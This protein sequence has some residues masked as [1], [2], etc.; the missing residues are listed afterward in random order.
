M[1]AQDD[2]TQG[3]D[4]I[5]RSAF[6]SGSTK[7]SYKQ[8]YRPEYDKVAA[9]LQGGAFP[10]PFPTTLMGSGL[11]KVERGRRNFPSEPPPPPPP[12]TGFDIPTWQVSS[13][14]TTGEGNPEAFQS[15]LIYDYPTT[16][17]DSWGGTPITAF[18]TPQADAARGSWEWWWLYEVNIPTS[19]DAGS[20][21]TMNALGLDAHNQPGDVGWNFEPGCASGVSSIH[22]R[23]KGGNLLLQHE[24]Q[25]DDNTGPNEYVIKNITE[26]GWHSVACQF[27]LG[28]L[29]GTIPASGHPNG[30]KGRTRIYVDG[31]LALD[32]GDINILQRD[33]CT[34]Q[35]QKRMANIQGLY[36]G[37]MSSSHT[38]QITAARAGKTLAQALAHSTFNFHEV[39]Y[40]ASGRK[41]DGTPRFHTW[42]KI[43]SRRSDQFIAPQV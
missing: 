39:Y 42:T 28:R 9:Y 15:W 25:Q 36:N 7:G 2:I 43:A 1:S 10:N 38:A 33:K 31:P 16:P 27:I 12:P 29:D 14:A 3:L 6:V 23:Y 8:K 34:G 13:T 19:W 20:E 17:V 40:N 5:F 11:T 26:G 41:A 21:G 22:L 35:I 32:T 30:G 18:W 24:R 37:G 4:E